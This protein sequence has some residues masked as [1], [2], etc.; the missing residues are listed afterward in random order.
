MK[1]WL[2]LKPYTLV[3]ILHFFVA[4]LS[5]AGV[6]L[7][8]KGLFTIGGDFNKQQLPFSY[9]INESIKNGNIF[10]NWSIDLGSDFV[11]SMSWYLI[12]SPFYL[13]SLIFPPES[14][15]YLASFM[16]MLK[17]AVAGLTSFMYISRFTEKNR[18]ALIGSVLYAFSGFQSVNLLF[19]HFHDVV[20]LFPLLLIGVE[21]ITEEKKKGCLLFA[22]CLC[23]LTNYYFFVQEAI[24]VIIYY[25]V[26]NGFRKFKDMIQCLIEGVLGLCCAAFLFLPSVLF[27]LENPRLSKFLPVEGWFSFSRRTVLWL[28]RIFFF[29]AELLGHQSCIYTGDWSSQSAYLPMIGLT[30]AISYMIHKKWNWIHRMLLVLVVITCVPLLN[31]MFVFFSETANHRW[32]FM[33]ILILSLASTQVM[34]HRKD[35]TIKTVVWTLLLLLCSMCL[36]FPWWNQNK[37]QLI[38]NQ[39]DFLVITAIG[40]AGIFITCLIFT[41]IK[42]ERTLYNCL[43]IGVIAFSV[44]TTSYTCQDYRR[45]WAEDTQAYYR[46]MLL[47]R[48]L[49]P[50]DE[51]YRHISAD[52][53]Q[54]MY[55]GIAGL[56]SW[57]STVNGSIFRFWDS[58]DQIRAFSNPHIEEETRILLGGRY[59]ISQDF[60]PNIVP[61]Q[62]ISSGSHTLYVYENELSLPIGFTYE[63]YMKQS[64]FDLLETAQKPYA[65]L[66]TLIIPDIWEQFVSSILPSADFNTQLSIEELTSLRSLTCSR[67]VSR[68][69]RGFSSEISTKTPTFAYFSV[70]YSP[71]WRVTVNN[72]PTEIINSNGMMAVPLETGTNTIQFTYENQL[73]NFGCILSCIALLISMQYISKRFSK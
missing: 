53:L 7:R 12:G 46:D 55:G 56:G 70:P 72:K 69:P 58:L 5:F 38:F 60:R 19:N 8:E 32:Y 66:Y 18:Y 40:L 61:S 44:V 41:F 14:Y 37:F 11:S 9:F 24:F 39:Q 10:W 31:S 67:Y 71:W 59:E 15:L 13:L 45:T 22:T 68:N 49:E 65:M 63:S 26:K 73:F 64:E 42:N 51:R 25:F 33:M 6:L 34:E 30:L 50:L 43:L 36:L 16:Y 4:F 62:V 47:Y 28:I 57:N 1:L 17:Y 2:K 54:T 23:A 29:P 27:I 52:N 48:Q 20:A 3:F 21:K 35:Y